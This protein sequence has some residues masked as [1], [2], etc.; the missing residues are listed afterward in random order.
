MNKAELLELERDAYARWEAVL[1]EVPPE[2]FTE[3]TM[4]GGWS[5]KDTVGHV[6]YY[7]RWLLHWL[8]DAVRGRVTAGTHRDIL[9]VEQR[10]AM[11]YKENKDRTQQEILTDARQVHDRLYQFVAML[12]ESQLL[13]PQYFERYIV[14]FWNRNWPLWHCIADDSYEH[15]DQHTANIRAWLTQ[16][17]GA[18]ANHGH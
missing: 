10:N 7:E 8:E 2:R 11:I 17:Q 9:N 6:A 5:V 12:P 16:T 15:Y 1:A 3:P 13:E 4:H 14:P 18:E